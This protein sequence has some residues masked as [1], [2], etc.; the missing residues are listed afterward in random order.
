MVLL[1]KLIQDHIRHDAKTL[2]ITGAIQHKEI[3][4]NITPHEWGPIV[5]FYNFIHT[6]DIPY[7]NIKIQNI[8]KYHIL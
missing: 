1:L 8:L 2:N 7:D 6:I 5:M 3:T 4:Y